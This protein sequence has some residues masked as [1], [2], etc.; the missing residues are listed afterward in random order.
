MSCREW[1]SGVE[2]N[3]SL[4]A[5]LTYVSGLGPPLAQNLLFLEMK[6]TGPFQSRAQLKKVRSIGDKAFEQA[7]WIF[8]NL[9][10]QAN[11]S[12]WSA[13]HPERLM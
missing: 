8:T 9:A 10:M 6:K 2:V 4:Q 1:K 13:V 11:Y 7:G 12:I 5:M 3:L